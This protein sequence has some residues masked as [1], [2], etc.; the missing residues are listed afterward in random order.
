MVN[1]QG[2]QPN[3]IPLLP[4]DTSPICSNAWLAGFTD[5]D[6]NFEVVDMVN[7][8]KELTGFKCR[9]RATT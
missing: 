1:L 6:E 4:L 7:A 3:P 9:F 2:F 5:S 8:K